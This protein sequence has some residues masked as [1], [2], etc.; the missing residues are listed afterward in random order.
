[1]L[2]TGLLAKLVQRASIHHALSLKHKEV[3]VMQRYRL[4]VLVLLVALLP[5]LAACEL[6][7][8]ERD[9]IQGTWTAQDGVGTEYILT[10]R[11]EESLTGSLDITTANGTGV[12]PVDVTGTYT[13]PSVTLRFNPPGQ[14]G[15]PTTGTVNDTHDRLTLNNFNDHVITFARQ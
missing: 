5:A 15:D 13:H 2:S 6:F 8:S 12:A 4:A 3:E 7:E 14:E 11:G 1:M 10:L 9:S